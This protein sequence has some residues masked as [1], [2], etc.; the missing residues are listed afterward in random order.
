MLACRVCICSSTHVPKP[1][2]IVY[3]YH[4]P[5]QLMRL[6]KVRLARVSCRLQAHL[7]R[8]L[9]L[10]LLQLLLCCVLLRSAGRQLLL[11][12]LQLLRQ[13]RQPCSLLRRDS[14]QLGQLA[15][16]LHSS[17]RRD[18]KEPHLNSCLFLQGLAVTGLAATEL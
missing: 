4:I 11:A 14:L 17:G 13:L 16:N 15:S 12:L 8:K 9:C 6:E 18:D 1:V 2:L 3:V 10:P 7:P 5:C